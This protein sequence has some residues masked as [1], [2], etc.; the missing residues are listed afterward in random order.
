[1]GLF[2][3]L[4]EDGWAHSSLKVMMDGLIHLGALLMNGPIHPVPEDDLSNRQVSGFRPGRCSRPGFGLLQQRVSDVAGLGEGTTSPACRRCNCNVGGSAV[5][6]GRRALQRWRVSDAA[7]AW[8]PA[9]G[10]AAGAESPVRKSDFAGN[11]EA[12][13]GLVVLSGA[14]RLM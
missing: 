11:P 14:A 2:I 13:L 12:G 7:A 6:R 3:A 1:M 9:L 8:P 4:I 5:L 10:Y